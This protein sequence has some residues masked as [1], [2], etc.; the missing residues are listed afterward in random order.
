MESISQIIGLIKNTGKYIIQKNK[1]GG[2]ILNQIH[3]L[4]YIMYIFEKYKLKK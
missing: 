1:G 3:D 2:V 4:D